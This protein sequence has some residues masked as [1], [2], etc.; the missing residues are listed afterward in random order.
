MLKQQLELLVTK[1]STAE[2]PPGL[3]DVFDYIKAL[4][5]AQ[6]DCISEL[7]TL[8]KLLLKLIMVI[9]ATST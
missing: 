7:V 5:L 2:Q 9:P 6:R 1:F 3:Q 4:S 8:L